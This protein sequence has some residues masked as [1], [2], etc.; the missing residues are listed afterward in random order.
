MSRI[1]YKHKT[2]LR[3]NPGGSE[4]L[5][6]GPT[7]EGYGLVRSTALGRELQT[8]GLTSRETWKSKTLAT[9]LFN[10]SLPVQS[11]PS[12]NLFSHSQAVVFRHA[13]QALPEPLAEVFDPA[14]PA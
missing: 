2:R 14:L 5:P 1:G 11:T 6:A 8:A 10:H 3:I 9:L 7:P 12:W 13:I 4:F